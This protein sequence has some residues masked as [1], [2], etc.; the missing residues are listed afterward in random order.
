MYIQKIATI[1][2][3]GEIHDILTGEPTEIF[4]EYIFISEPSDLDNLLKK[5]C[6]LYEDNS[7]ENV[8]NYY[9]SSTI[10]EIKEALILLEKDE[11]QNV[12]FVY[13]N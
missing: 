13:Q 3:D 11:I 1:L 7:R 5:L 12:V 4:Q 2:M 9:I 10:R 6:K 8:E